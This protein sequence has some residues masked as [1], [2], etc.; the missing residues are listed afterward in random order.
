M[1]WLAHNGKNVNVPRNIVQWDPAGFDVER[2]GATRSPIQSIK[3]MLAECPQSPSSVKIVFERRFDGYLQA[4]LERVCYPPVW[5][6]FYCLIGPCLF[7][8]IGPSK[9]TCTPPQVVKEL[10]YWQEP[11]R[12]CW[13]LS[14]WSF[15]DKNVSIFTVEI[16]SLFAEINCLL[17]F[18]SQQTISR[19]PALP[20]QLG[21]VLRVLC[22]DC[23]PLHC[24]WLHSHI[25]HKLV[26]LR[27]RVHLANLAQWKFHWF[28]KISSAKHALFRLEFTET[29]VISFS[30]LQLVPNKPLLRNRD[31]LFRFLVPLICW[32]DLL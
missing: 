12:V 28:M 27:K 6:L 4:S 15:H 26:L 7:E 13:K 25:F 9:S 19:V 22:R 5:L 10:L 31:L 1:L 32:L 11:A 23:Y 24:R 3:N 17:Q 21:H 8:S 20:G 30:L 29:C 14:I 2:Y 18:P 16:L